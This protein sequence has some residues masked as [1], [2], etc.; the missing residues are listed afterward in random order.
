MKPVILRI[1]E[2]STFDPALVACADGMLASENK[3][4][5]ILDAHFPIEQEIAG[6]SHG[7]T[8]LIDEIRLS[9]SAL[10]PTQ[11]LNVPEPSSVVLAAVGLIGLAACGWRRRLH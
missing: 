7:F 3:L 9:Y 6:R 2:T 1:N 11:L 5:T 4:H 8:G 10:S